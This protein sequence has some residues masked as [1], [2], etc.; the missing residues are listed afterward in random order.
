MER[1][2][3]SRDHFPIYTVSIPSGIPNF[4]SEAEEGCYVT[5]EREPEPTAEREAEQKEE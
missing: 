2:R 3:S 1:R 5:P 4:E